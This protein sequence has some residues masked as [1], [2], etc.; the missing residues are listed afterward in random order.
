MPVPCPAGFALLLCLSTLPLAAQ[1]LYGLPAGLP[2][3]AV[4]AMGPGKTGMRLL[5]GLVIGPY[6]RLEGADL[7]GAD[8][9]GCDL[10]GAR[11]DGADCTGASFRGATLTA[12][13]LRG[14]CLFMADF[15]GSRGLC[16]A[17]AEPHPFFEPAGPDEDLGSLRFFYTGA[18]ETDSGGPRNP[19]ASPFGGIFWIEGTLGALRHL[20]PTGVKFGLRI[21]EEG[22]GLH[23]LGKDSENRLWA[24][25]DQRFGWIPL[26]SFDPGL[27]DHPHLFNSRPSAP[28]P[29]LFAVASGSRG[30]VMVS[31]P[32]GMRH[33]HYLDGKYREDRILPGKGSS[34]SDVAVPSQD[35]TRLFIAGP[36][37]KDI[38]AQNATGQGGFVL[39]LPEGCRA[40]RIASAWDRRMWFTQAGRIEG[41]GCIDEDTGAVSFHPL[42]PVADGRARV[43]WALA[44]DA[45]GNLWF[46]QRGVCGLGRVTPAGRISEYPLPEGFHAREIAPGHDGRMFF[47]VEGE[48]LIG[49][50]LALPPVPAPASPAL[51]VESKAAAA[52]WKVPC[53]TPPRPERRKPLTD[54]ER[55]DRHSARLLAAERRFQERAAR[56][57]DPVEEVKAQAGPPVP[58][59]GPQE[60]LAAMDVNLTPGAVRSILA[61]H[62]FGRRPDKSQFA[63][64]FSTPEGLAG[65]IA[66]GMENAGA[67]ARVRISD[68]EGHYLTFC[69]HPEAGTRF[70]SEV[71]TS[72]FVVRTVRH[73]SGEGFEHDVIGAYPT[74]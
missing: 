52:D 20:S 44:P 38:L 35:G 71:P 2:P 31:G 48:R 10:T 53:Y 11:L 59:A 68:A 15:Q 56:G 70:G 21:V 55:H 54:G 19:V 42:A 39:R 22:Q 30:D 63:P 60:R 8:L 27:P 64:G 24:F 18:E 29:A 6:A 33:C 73:F 66:L 69:T 62:G 40:N 1:T 46:T 3:G 58:V 67:I 51:P 23:V 13:E 49:S 16:V 43:P 41:I 5:R 4:G 7:R 34:S 14:A 32:D 17:G 61:K 65:L 74:H 36:E 26:T 72:R 12:A 37:R 50:V 25:G 57:A 47:T 9:S 45:E 28:G